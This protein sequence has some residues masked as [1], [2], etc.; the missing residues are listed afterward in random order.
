[1]SVDP[2]K[3]GPFREYPWVPTLV[4]DHDKDTITLVSV[5]DDTGERRVIGAAKSYK[6]F[7]NEMVEGR[8]RRD[9][10]Q[11]RGQEQER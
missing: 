7:V 4:I 1:M 6:Q 11:E 2:D 9:R 5:N 3:D 10:E 8:L